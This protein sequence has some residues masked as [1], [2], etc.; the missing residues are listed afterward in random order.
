MLKS[1]QLTNNAKIIKNFSYELND[2]YCMG[3]TLLSVA[4]LSDYKNYINLK[5]NKIIYPKIKSDLSKLKTMGY[6]HELI[7]IISYMI[8]DLEEQRITLKAIL[9][10]LE[11]NLINF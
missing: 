3:L 5:G 2:V 4:A 11:N 1:P 9:N 8:E 6:S 10:I 7:K